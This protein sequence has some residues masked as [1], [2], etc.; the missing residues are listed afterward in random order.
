MKQFLLMMAVIGLAATGCAQNSVF[1]PQARRGGMNSQAARA[2]AGIRPGGHMAR[3]EVASRAN[4]SRASASRANASRAEQSRQVEMAAF[5]GGGYEGG[6][7]DNGGYDDTCC[8]GNCTANSCCGGSCDSGCCGDSSCGA[9]N[10]N[11]GNGSCSDGCSNCRGRGCGL[12]Q[13]M[14]GLNPHA[15]G[16]PEAQ[17]FN[18]SP[19]TGQ[20]AYPYYTVRGPRDFLR[21]NPPSIGPY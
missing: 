11:C 5:D 17:N 4:T 19:A 12:C 3:R 1:G 10:G 9:G 20:V 14:S 13:R 15:G 7:Y 21:N 16:Y 6:G 8:S 2:N 18:P